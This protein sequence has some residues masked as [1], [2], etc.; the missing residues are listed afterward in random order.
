[1]QERKKPG[2]PARNADAQANKERPSRVP[3]GAGNKLQSPKKEGYQRYWS[4]SGPDHPGQIEQMEA[5]WWEIVKREDGTDWTVPAGK[6]NMHVLM[7]I[8]QEYYDQ[9]MAE[10]QKRNM[11]ATQKSV[12]ALGEDE[13]LPAGR[14]AVVEREL[15]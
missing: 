15:I 5:A 11:D 3:M 8:P 2:R 10:Q 1:M 4:I 6:G 13:Y 14:K 7:Q 9:D 12:Q